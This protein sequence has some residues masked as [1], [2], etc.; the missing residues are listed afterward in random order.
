MGYSEIHCQICGVG[1]NIGRIRTA[2]EPRTAAWTSTRVFPGTYV[3]SKHF[4]KSNCPPGCMVALRAQRSPW[5]ARRRGYADP[6]EPASA[7]P[8]GQGDMFP[9]RPDEVP[10]D[11]IDRRFHGIGTTHNLEHIAGPECLFEPV[12]GGG[13]SGHNISLQEMAGCNTVQCLVR[14]T[15]NWEPEDGDEE[16]EKAGAFFL[17]GLSDY[18]PNRDGPL[19]SVFPVRHGCTRPRPETTFWNE[20]RTEEYALPF[21]TTC[22]EVFKQASLHRT[23]NIDI[24]ALTGWWEIEGD[25]KRTPDFPRDPAVTKSPT[26]YWCHFQGD[27]YLVADPCR[28]PGLDS[29]LEMGQQAQELNTTQPSLIVQAEP[30]LQEPATQDPFLRLPQEVR[31]M[32]LLEVPFDDVVNLQLSSRAFW[33]IGDAVFRN[34]VVRDWP[35]MW[36]AWSTLGYSSWAS[37]TAEELGKM[38]TLPLKPVKSNSDD[39]GGDQND[40]QEKEEAQRGDDSPRSKSAPESGFLKGTHAIDWRKVRLAAGTKLVGNQLKGLRNRERI[41]KDCEEI[42]HRADIYRREGKM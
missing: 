7:Q 38:A 11:E 33:D 37:K 19:P 20:E 40:K 5:G 6:A 2:S 13:Y 34:L 24:A 15:P 42:L 17:S 9:E 12:L 10:E 14:K 31:T 22:L 27:E 16:F 29:L 4:T 25:H 18:M 39:A 35:W 8:A 36:E 26:N 21:H 1:F 41:W 23:G 28:V 30:S 32:I 3:G